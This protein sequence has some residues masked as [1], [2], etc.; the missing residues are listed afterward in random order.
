MQ[1]LLVCWNTCSWGSELPLGG[2][3]TLRLP[4]CE[5][6]PATW[7]VVPQ[8][9]LSHS[10]LG[11]RQGVKWP[12]DVSS[13]SHLSHLLPVSFSHSWSSRRQGQAISRTPPPALC[14]S[15]C[16]V[17]WPS[18]RPTESVSIISWMRFCASGLW[19]GS[20]RYYRELEVLAIPFRS[21][22]VTPL[23]VSG[24]FCQRYFIN[25]KSHLFP[26]N[27]F[28]VPMVVYHT[29]WFFSLNDISWR[30]SNYTNSASSFLFIAAWY[31]II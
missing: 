9:Q 16:P 18:S 22:G 4:C 3:T 20:L 27:I 6:A 8:W 30:F 29:L 2:L 31:F 14:P 5:E 10:S 15:P 12:S 28:L 11:G 26:F 24:V 17:P 25:I 23:P 21:Q 1:C 19:G 13:S 7:H